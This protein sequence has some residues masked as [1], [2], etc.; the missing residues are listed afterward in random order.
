MDNFKHK[1]IN[2]KLF[3]NKQNF[4]HKIQLQFPPTFLQKN[5]PKTINQSNKA[6]SLKQTAKLSKNL[7]NHPPN[8]KSFSRKQFQKRL[9]RHKIKKMFKQANQQIKSCLSRKLAEI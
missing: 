2:F 6:L 5:N 1:I 7:N 4:Q 8:N 9:L 3:K